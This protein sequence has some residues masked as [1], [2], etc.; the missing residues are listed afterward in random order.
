VKRLT[1][2]HRNVLEQLIATGW[3]EADA[4]GIGRTL[5]SLTRRGYAVRQYNF[6]GGTWQYRPTPLGRQVLF[7]AEASA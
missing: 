7:E 6:V 5:A 1:D 4:H 3:I 2:Q